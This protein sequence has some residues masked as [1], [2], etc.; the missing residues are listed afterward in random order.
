ML[1]DWSMNSIGSL[2]RSLFLAAGAWLIVSG[3]GE[4]TTR[5]QGNAYGSWL[6]ETSFMALG[7]R[8]NGSLK[9]GLGLSCLAGAAVGLSAQGSASP[10]GL[11][12]LSSSAGSGDSQKSD[13]TKDGDFKA[14]TQ[15]YLQKGGKKKP[16]FGNSVIEESRVVLCDLYGTPLANFDKDDSGDW[17]CRGFNG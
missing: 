9:I 10:S 5:S 12:S 2:S 13:G 16:V 11:E 8:S 6:D 14:C 1:L 4:L 7:M 3:A 17:Y 15:L